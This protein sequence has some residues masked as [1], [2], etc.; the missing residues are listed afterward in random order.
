[1]LKDEHHKQLLDYPL[2]VVLELVN[3]C[4]LEC[5]MCYQG[6]RNDTNKVTVNESVLDK[7]FDDFKKN[8]LSAL[9]LT[10]SEPLLYKNIGHVLKRAEEAKIMDTF[11][12]TN[13]SLLDRKKSEMI[14]NSCV[15]RLFVSIDAATEETYDKVRI[16]V[17]KNRLQSNRLE[18]LEKKIKDFIKLR[19]ELGKKLPL[20]RVSFV[21][22]KENQHEIEKFKEKWKGIVDSVEIQRETSINLY[23]DIETLEKDK[24]YIPKNIDY[25]CNKPWGDMAIYSDG[26]V[27][28]C[29]NL[30]GRMSPIGNVNEKTVFEIWN[31]ETMSKLREG[32]K[33]NSPN[34]ICKIC[35][36]NQE[37]NI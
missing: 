18:L 14:I 17:G 9:M 2:S 37:T 5:V 25:N 30:V 32:F 4:D 8:E 16:P 12:F 7:I 1:M 34:D 35:I 10:A 13:G 15:T 22:L 3:R 6:F 31:G 36:D 21:A 23:K 20:T 26:R 24:S 27:G 11:I 28:P 19:N 33:N 29:C